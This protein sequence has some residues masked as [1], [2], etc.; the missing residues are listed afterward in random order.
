MSLE[1]QIKAS[2][3]IKAVSLKAYMTSLRGIKKAL[4]DDAELENTKFLHDYGAVM[5]EIKK[6]KT[7]CQKNKITAVIV[8]LKSDKKPRQALIDKYT[9]ALAKLNDEYIS[10]LR[11]QKKTETQAKNWLEYDEV[12][13]VVNGL[14]RTFKKIDL[15][16]KKPL[17]NKEFD[18]LQQLVVLRTYLTFP[19]RNDFADM[20]VLTEKKY[21]K[22]PEDTKDANNYLVE[23]RDGTRAFHIN[24]FKNRRFMDNKILDIPE[25]INKLLKLWL[26]HNTSG[27]F[28]VK[29]NRTD[30][31]NPNGITKYLNK[32]FKPTG[33]KISTS[34]LRHILI[35]HHMKDK[36]TIAEKDEKKKEI[37]DTYMHSEALNDL[38]R[39]VD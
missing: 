33:K 11:E 37:E 18:T 24:Q 8:A 6:C 34:M 35:S 31:M 7:T 12:I 38:Y 25:N 10:M 14:T 13:N 1:E 4:T 36:P 20:P 29:T 15:T 22:L 26:K 9:S 39:K 30:P 27:W 23:N 32:I 17:T 21:N 5:S 16:K 19:L 2:R 28:L 3:D